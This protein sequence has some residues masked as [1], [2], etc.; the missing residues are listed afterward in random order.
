MDIFIVMGDF[1]DFIKFIETCH[2][3]LNNHAPSK[4]KVY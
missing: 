1:I 4:K 2:E 3:T